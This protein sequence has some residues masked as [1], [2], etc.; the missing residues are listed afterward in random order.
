MT[1][2]MARQGDILLIGVASIPEEAKLREAPEDPDGSIVLA[3]GEA[4]GHRHRI[5]IVDRGAVL[6]EEEGL[7]D[8]FLEVLAEGGVDLVHEEHATIHLP[9]GDFIV[10]R[11]REYEP[12]ALPRRV[13]D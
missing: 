5:A 2:F 9:P 7:E 3:N 11:Q 10:R 13:A 6:Y 1:R 12:G 8:R 4:T